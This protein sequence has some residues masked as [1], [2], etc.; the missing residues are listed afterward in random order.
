MSNEL[1]K[2]SKQSSWT[3]KCNK[4]A[5][6]LKHW[7]YEDSYKSNGVNNVWNLYCYIYKDHPLFNLIDKDSDYD[8]DICRK[9]PMHYGCSF[10]QRHI[11]EGEVR[12]YQIGCDYNHYGDQFYQDLS[13]DDGDDY[14]I[15]H[16]ENLYNLLQRMC[17]DPTLIHREDEV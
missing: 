7:S 3:R 10:F 14:M 16:A 12:S 17:D 4:F 5:V 6:E 11:V 1:N 2:Y 8:Q 15:F 13:A 9:I